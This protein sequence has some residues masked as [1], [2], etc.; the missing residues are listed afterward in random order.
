MVEWE[1]TRKQDL[2]NQKMKTQEEVLKLKGKKKSLAITMEQVN[3]RFNELN[4]T[5]GDTRKKVVEVK[6]EIDSMRLQRDTKLGL[7]SSIKAQIKALNDRQLF[8][9]QEKLKLAQ[10]LKSS[11][12]AGM[13]SLTPFPCFD[14]F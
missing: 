5:V 10:Q 13:T 4:A 11:A 3:N 14:E 12:I 1:N 8:I 2:I 9:E 6:A 7:L